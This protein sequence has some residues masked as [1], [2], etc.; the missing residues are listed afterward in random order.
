[1]QAVDAH[2]DRFHP[3]VRWSGAAGRRILA[4]SRSWM[5]LTE[6]MADACVRDAVAVTQHFAASGGLLSPRRAVSGGL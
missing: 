4:L 3:F 6:V 5:M 1:M 2:L